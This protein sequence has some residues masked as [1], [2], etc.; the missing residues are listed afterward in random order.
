M[1]RW[2]LSELA[3]EAVRSLRAALW[4]T[5]FGVVAAGIIAA[6]IATNEFSTLAGVADRYWSRLEAGSGVVAA[7]PAS[8]EFPIPAGRCLSLAAGAGIR[9]SGAILGSGVV[10]YLSIPGAS[11]AYGL[12][13]PGLLDVLGGHPE[14]LPLEDGVFLGA[15]LAKDLPVSPGEE[16]VIAP[17]EFDGEWRVTV[18]GVV[19]TTRQPDLGGWLF[20]PAAAT[21]DAAESCWVET[22]PQ[23]RNTLQ[24]VVAVQLGS[25]LTDPVVRALHS[26]DPTELSLE[27]Q[28]R[29]RI[30]R[31]GWVVGAAVFFLL[32]ALQALA[33]RPRW[34]LYRILGTSMG[35]LMLLN[36]FR[37]ALVVWPAAVI[38][39]AAASAIAVTTSN[40]A[41]IDRQLLDFGRWQV[42]MFSMVVVSAAPIATG[43]AATG[44]VANMLRER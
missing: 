17:R 34:A 38:G 20:I 15:D 25:G 23:G 41:L 28:W 43:L 31:H 12:V 6:A 30:S 13:T 16:I 7:F 22:Q 29:E 40:P 26:D 33:M 18:A 37:T 14:D 2:P 5:T 39:W 32:S 44:A 11:S 8:D 36:V 19:D 9:G 10:D 24:S 4:M 21:N 42:V 27:T 3:R 35:E 1:S